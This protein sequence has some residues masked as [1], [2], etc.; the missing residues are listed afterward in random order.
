MTLNRPVANPD[1]VSTLAIDVYTR[2]RHIW[3]WLTQMDDQRAFSIGR[4]R[5]SPVA[6]VVRNRSLLFTGEQDG[7]AW[8][9]E[10]AILPLEPGHT[11]LIS[12]SR[13]RVP[14][15]LGARVFMWFLRP[16][17]FIMTRRMLAGLKHRAEGLAAATREDVPVAA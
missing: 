14:R 13:A 17:A 8:S 1:Y 5:R 12:R 4:R 15:T 9:C 11:L 3:T 2:P 7:Y 10:F 6:R 16:A